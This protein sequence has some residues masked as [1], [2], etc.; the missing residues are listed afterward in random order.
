[1]RSAPLHPTPA[2]A[3]PA[4]RLQIPSIHEENLGNQLEPE[5]SFPDVAVQTD[6]ARVEREIMVEIKCCCF[7]GYGRGHKV[8]MGGFQ[9]FD[10]EDEVYFGGSYMN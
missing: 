4:L 3:L 7:E 1:M 2:K 9:Y 8:S 10:F 6:D 5:R